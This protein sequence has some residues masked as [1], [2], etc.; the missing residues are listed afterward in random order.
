[1]Y[2]SKKQYLVSET[3]FDE[4]YQLEVG[5]AREICKYTFENDIAIMTLEI[6]TPRVQEV[7]KDTKVTFPDM[8]GTV[9]N[10]QSR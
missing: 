1:M 10:D 5:M 4:K 9:G 8:L 6:A 3:A 7:V 2:L